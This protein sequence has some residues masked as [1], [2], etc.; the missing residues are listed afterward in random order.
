MCECSSSP[1]HS[2]SL[3]PYC[4]FLF[5]KLV[6]WLLK[7]ALIKRMKMKV[8]KRNQIQIPDWAPQSL[9]VRWYL[10]VP[11]SLRGNPPLNSDLETKRY[12][13]KP[14]P[15][16]VGC[17]Q[18][19]VLIAIL[20][21]CMV[22]GKLYLKLRVT[23]IMEMN[24]QV[25]PVLPNFEYSHLFRKKKHPAWIMVFTFFF[26]FFQENPCKALFFTII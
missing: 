25:E 16:F 2:F 4:F 19:W 20:R 6:W 24:F 21:F 10:S 13:H 17:F 3:I 22:K 11:M 8:W 9:H 15:M 26:F 14:M 23:F 12:A 18:F 5:R 1:T 7:T